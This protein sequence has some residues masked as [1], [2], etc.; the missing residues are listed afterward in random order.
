MTNE[1]LLAKLEDS[2]KD[3][4]LHQLQTLH[5]ILQH[6]AGV[7]YLWPFLSGYHEPIDAETFRR[8]VPLSSYEDYADHISRMANGEPDHDHPFLSVDPLVCFFY[9]SGTSTMKPK[10]IPY[11]DS[12]LSKA[13][14][15]LAHNG[16]N[17]IFRRL[18][19]PRPVVNK[20]LWFLYADDFTTT[21]GGF[22]AV[23]ASTYPLLKMSKAKWSE[24][25]SCTSPPEV[26]SGTNVK[27]Q[28]YCHLLCALRN[29]DLIDGI[30]AP[31]AI[32]LVKA[33]NLLESKWGQLCDDLENGFPDM[34]ITD[35]AMRE[36]V[37]KVLNGP[38]PDLS[39]RLRSIFEE[40][41]WG[42]I[43]SK[44]WSNVR[45]VKCV[46]TGSMK[47]YYSKLKYYAGEVIILEAT[48]FAMLPT[49]AYF[50]F[51]PFDLNEGSVVGKETVNFSGVEVG[52]TYE[53]VVTTYR[54]I[55]RYRLGDIVRVVGFHNS[56][57]EVEFVMRAPKN[58]YEVITERDLMSAVESF[59]LVMRNAIAAE[60]VEF[61]SFLDLELSPKQLKIFLEVKEGFG[62]LQEEKLQESVESLKWCCSSLEKGLGGIYKV[63]RD[64]GE[65]GPL[66]VYIVKP[67]SFDRILQMAVENGAPASQYK[68]PK[69]IRNS[70]VIGVMESSALVTVC[71][72]SL[73]GF[74]P[75]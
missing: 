60:I 42:G 32:G 15:Y 58:A 47:H 62:L 65:I 68:P 66:L 71:L 53:V 6:Q 16:S 33:F 75:N 10:L 44:L 56:S 29:S 23:A 8:L 69:I 7:R 26:I 43:V 37:A 72:D 54:G 45:Y 27:N 20:I 19:P 9:S 3:A 40:K 63:Q 74:D 52:K 11:F 22:N 17:A 13:A 12:A 35:P 57:P 70:R 25:L 28:M 24:A 18:I 38:Q 30:R 39:N 21:R 67:G 4:A 34:Q 64:R 2:T 31:Y 55:Y 1:E 51:L 5:S 46:T 14:S 41:N 73:D 59:Q 48:R 50:E 49:A 61:A 36:S